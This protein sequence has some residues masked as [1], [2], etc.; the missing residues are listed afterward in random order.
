MTRNAA[1]ALRRP[2]DASI[3]VVRAR[4]WA[5]AASGYLCVGISCWFAIGGMRW[6]DGGVS[7]FF[8]S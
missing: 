6:G 3:A 7:V 1:N 8:P 4:S 2:V 5:I